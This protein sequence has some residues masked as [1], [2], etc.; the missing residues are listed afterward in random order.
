MPERSDC[1]H[2]SPSKHSMLSKQQLHP[3]CLIILTPSSSEPMLQKNPKEEEIEPT[4][5]EV[6]QEPPTKREQ[7]P[8]KRQPVAVIIAMLKKGQDQRG[9]CSGGRR[10]MSV[11]TPHETLPV[12]PPA[13]SSSSLTTSLATACSPHPLP[14][15][16]WFATTLWSE[17]ST[18][19][20]LIT[21]S[22]AFVA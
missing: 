2:S 4:R 16:I 11:S 1:L 10:S 14:T 3:P 6:S 21:S 20:S 8:D 5:D 15:V 18:S 13:S 12:A 19:T 9:R 17:I 22:G 7:E